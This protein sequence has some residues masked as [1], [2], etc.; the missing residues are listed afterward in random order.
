VNKI[1]IPA[2]IIALQ[3]FA[4]APALAA[5]FTVTNTNDV[6][7]GSLRQAIVDAVA[8][9]SVSHDN[10]IAFDIPGTGVH[11]IRPASPLP[12][13][14]DLTID[15]YTQPGSRANTLDKGSDAILTIELDGTNAGASANGLENQGA[16]PGAGP[17]NV[18]VRRRRYPRHWSGWRRLSG[19]RDAAR[20]LHRY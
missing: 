4:S 13:I 10:L 9:P 6:G 20:L 19:F 12:P 5:T 8:N 7:A 18:T 15:G 3:W 17:P 16:V 11:T 14:K 2:T 1:L